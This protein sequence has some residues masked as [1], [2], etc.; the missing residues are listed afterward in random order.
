MDQAVSDSYSSPSAILTRRLLPQSKVFPMAP[1]TSLALQRLD[2]LDKSSPDFQDQLNDLLHENE[3]Q[4]C[5]PTLQGD[6]LM[7]LVD[8]LDEVR[9]RVALPTLRSSCR[10]LSTSS[11]LPIWLPQS[12]YMNSE[13]YAAT[14]RYSQ[15]RTTFRLIST[16]IPAQPSPM[17]VICMRGPS[18]VQ[19]SASKVYGCTV[20][21]GR[22]KCVIDPVGFPVRQR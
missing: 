12:Y 22:L 19:K 8:Y 3:Y 7:W 20:N 16:P 6:E 14:G 11:A 13:T 21:K 9:H 5:V 4:E 2:S 15:R 17:I 18:T 10:R 1:P